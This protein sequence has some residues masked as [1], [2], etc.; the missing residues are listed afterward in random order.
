M[1]DKSNKSS[2]D[3]NLANIIKWY[4]LPLHVEVLLLHVLLYITRGSTTSES[5]EEVRLL[6]DVLMLPVVTCKLTRAL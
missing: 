3:T 4:F 6:H 1:C 2:V 5:V